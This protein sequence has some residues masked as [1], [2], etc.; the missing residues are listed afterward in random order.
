MDTASCFAQGA[1]PYGA[2][3]LMASGL[4]AISPLEIIPH[5]YYPMAIGVMVVLSIVFQFPR[6]SES[7]R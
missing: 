1:L 6:I 7:K 2:Q 5:L 4:A 3:L